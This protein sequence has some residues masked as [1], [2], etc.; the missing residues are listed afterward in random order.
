VC[1][2]QKY[3]HLT[4]KDPNLFGYLNSKLNLFCRPTPRVAPHDSLIVD[5]QII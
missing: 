4:L 5:A 2:F 3:I 1:G